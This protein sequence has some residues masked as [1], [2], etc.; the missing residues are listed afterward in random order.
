MYT[1]LPFILRDTEMSTYLELTNKLIERIN[2]VTLETADFGDAPGIH[3]FAKQ[4]INDAIREINNEEFQWPFNVQTLTEVLVADGTQLYSLPSGFKAVDMHTFYLIK[5]TALDVAGRPLPHK[6]YDEWNR[7][8]R[9]SDEEII[10]NIS[11]TTS[12]PEFVF[13]TQDDKF[14]VTPPPSKAYTVKATYWAPPADLSDST[15]TTTIPT[16]FEYLIIE[17]AMEKMNLFK[18]NLELARANR[19]VFLKGIKNMRSQIINVYQHVYDL[20]TSHGMGY[21]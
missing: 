16:R 2:E 19:S 1:A 8:Y 9:A 3:A 11:N 4:A 14:G 6:L 10:A 15:D 12:V 20:R 13:K 17:G 21:R 5:D 7:W 18:D